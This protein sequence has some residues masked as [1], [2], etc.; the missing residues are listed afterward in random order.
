MA[1]ET[2]DDGFWVVVM[3]E[4]LTGMSDIS[5]DAKFKKNI[6]EH[7]RNFLK[8]DPRKLH[9]ILLNEVNIFHNF[10]SKTK[11]LNIFFS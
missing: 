7:F 11:I 2:A 8:N 1:E 3:R 6:F 9:I 5:N 10:E 4:E